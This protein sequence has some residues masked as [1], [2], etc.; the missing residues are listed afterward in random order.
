MDRVFAY[1]ARDASGQPVRGTIMARD[2][3]AAAEALRAR[4]LLV[5]GLGAAGEAGR[6]LG[7][8]PAG[9]AAAAG[10]RAGAMRRLSVRGLASLSRHLSVLVRAGVGLSDALETLARQAEGRNERRM[11]EMV[12]SRVDT[13]DPLAGAL[14]E[15]GAFPPLFVHMVEAGEAAGRLD[16]VLER[17]AGY[18][19]RDYEL[20]QKVKGALTYPAVVASFAVVVVGV[21]IAFV[22]P[23]FAGTLAGADIPLPRI[24]LAVMG[25]GSFVR[26]WWYAILGVPA[27]AALGAALALRGEAARANLDRAMLGVPV[28][29]R[30]LEKVIV[31]RFAETLAS[32]VAAGV[33]I[34][35]SLEIVEKVVGNRHIASGIRLVRSGVREGAGVA[36]P[37]A[38]AGVFPPVVA[39]MLAVGEEG[40]AVDSMLTQLAG[41]YQQEVDR[42]VRSLTALIEPAVVVF[43]G[44]GVALVVASVILPMFQMVQVI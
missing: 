1:R 8:R 36:A 24:T 21:L 16:E 18:Y 5:T 32:L 22:I 31:V 44:V 3:A 40:G 27:V 15:T 30:L 12:K 25:L 29:G 17:L 7:V 11:L 14:E 38:E 34:L 33:P 42:S 41:F 43:L 9:E 19:E 39:R 10:R 13:G 37:L 23:R 6:A 28:V 4:G 2:E 35:Q 20:R 26:T